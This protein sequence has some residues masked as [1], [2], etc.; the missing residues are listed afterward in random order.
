MTGTL[1]FMKR[2]RGKRWPTGQRRG[3]AAPREQKLSSP[4]QKSFDT[5]A[6]TTCRGR[7]TVIPG[8]I[9]PCTVWTRQPHLLPANW[10]RLMGPAG[11]GS[12]LSGKR[13]S[14]AAFGEDKVPP[15]DQKSFH[16][17]QLQHPGDE[18]RDQPGRRMPARCRNPNP[19][20]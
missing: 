17:L 7:K 10:L 9:R 15:P 16:N 13:R 19:T 11:C 1:G 20:S 8:S 5:F 18:D 3:P 14:P 6:T 12:C 4:D 2:A